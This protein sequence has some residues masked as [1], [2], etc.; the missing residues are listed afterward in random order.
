MG[1]VS[2]V[3]M[4]EGESHEQEKQ[5]RKRNGS[6]MVYDVG[7]YDLPKQKAK[8]QAKMFQFM[9]TKRKGKKK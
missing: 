7:C 9:K 4:K 1:Q 5:N 8:T 2:R 6:R 3:Y